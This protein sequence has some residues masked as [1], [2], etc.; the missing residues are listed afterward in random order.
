[1]ERREFLRKGLTLGTAALLPGVGLTASNL[2]AVPSNPSTIA[3]QANIDKIYAKFAKEYG[4]DS[5]AQAKEEDGMTLL[6]L[7]AG[8]GKNKLVKFLVSAGEDVNVKN[9]HGATPL[10]EAACELCGYGLRQRLKI[11]KFLVSQGA[12]V[13]AKGINGMTPLQCASVFGFRSTNKIAKFLLSVGT[14]IHIRYE[15]GGDTLLH[16]T[17]A[18]SSVKDIK[19]LVAAGADV[20]AR[21]D[22]GYTPLHR[23]NTPDV[24]VYR[25]LVSVGADV[26][27]KANDGHTLLDSRVRWG[28]L[29]DNAEVIE[30]L[31]SIGAKSGSEAL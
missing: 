22:D 30:Y 8:L 26:N 12:D 23:A 4:Y 7:A 2:L 14:N 31:K 21:N 11:V 5:V 19:L 15:N 16:R 17:V 1:M 6:H 20:H 24:E 13:N 18:D 9:K 29:F 28:R 3:G 25:F 10:H 27:A